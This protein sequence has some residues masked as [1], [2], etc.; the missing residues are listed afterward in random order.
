[1][2]N[3]YFNKMMF[4]RNM[5]CLSVSVWINTF[6]ICVKGSMIST[7]FFSIGLLSV[8]LKI[9]INGLQVSVAKSPQEYYIMYENVLCCISQAF[10]RKISFIPLNGTFQ[11]LHST[12]QNSRS[13]IMICDSLLLSY[14]NFTKVW[15]HCVKTRKTSFPFENKIDPFKRYFMSMP[16]PGSI[17]LDLWFKI[18]LCIHL[19][20]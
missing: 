6:R 20:Y 13:S 11:E 16:N 1:M 9:Y 15:S 3:W 18:Y 5:L 17:I 19:L 7:R 12:V 10:S 14:L 2:I 4:L 8:R